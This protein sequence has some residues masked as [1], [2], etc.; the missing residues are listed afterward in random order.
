MHCIDTM[1]CSRLRCKA[2]QVLKY[3][4]S[5]DLHTCTHY[6]IPLT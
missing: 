4:H 6:V 3:Y 5:V 2:A 1:L